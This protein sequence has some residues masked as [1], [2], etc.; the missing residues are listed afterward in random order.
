ML[1][2]RIGYLSALQSVLGAE[3]GSAREDTGYSVLSSNHRRHDGACRLD[4]EHHAP[5][6]LRWCRC[7]LDLQDIRE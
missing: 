4:L 3:D 2:I 1:G 6:V 7:S 5:S